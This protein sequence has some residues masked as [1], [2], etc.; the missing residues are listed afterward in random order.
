MIKALEVIA[1]GEQECMLIEQEE[2]AREAAEKRIKENAERA[3]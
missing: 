2:K 3:E 1:E